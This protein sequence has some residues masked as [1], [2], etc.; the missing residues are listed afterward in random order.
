MHIVRGYGVMGHLDGTKEEPSELVEETSEKEGKT[1][2]SSTPDPLYEK[3]YSQDQQV[4]AWINS[5]LSPE[6]LAQVIDISSARLLWVTLNK[7]YA[8]HS[9]VRLMHLRNELQNTKRDGKFVE[10]YLNKMEKNFD[11]LAIIQHLVDE[12]EKARII[13]GGLG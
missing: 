1:I 5:T 6:I 3:W 10:E 12:E 13:L 11:Q 9:E 7:S 2:T 4:I 8:Q